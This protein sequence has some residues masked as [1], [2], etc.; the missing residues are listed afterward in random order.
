MAGPLLNTKF[1]IPR[2]RTSTVD[3]PRVSDL[4]DQGA[5]AKL[6]VLSAQAGFGKTTAIANWVHQGP[7]P[8]SVSWVSLESTDT[9]PDT[10]WTYVVTALAKQVP[11][12]TDSVLPLL[13][14]AKAP[15][16]AALTELLNRLAEA[17]HE[18]YLVLDDY[19][20]AET[21]DV[22]EGMTFLLGNLPPQAHLLLSTRSDPDLPLSRLRARGE[23]VEV[24]ASD[25]RFTTEEV[26][27]YL[28]GA[29]LHLRPSDLAVLAERTEGW[30]AALQL[31]AL[32]LRDRSDISD[33]IADFAGDDRFIVDY[34]VDEV[35]ARQPEPV[36]Q[37]LVRTCILE[38]LT[39]PLCDAVTGHAASDLMLH[40]LDRK[41][42][43]VIPLDGRRRWYR[44]HHL[45]AD[46]LRTH[47]DT[48]P[49]GPS[50]AELHSR[51]SHWYEDDGQPVDAVRHALAAGNHSRAATLMEVSLPDLLRRRQE[52]TVRSWIDTLSDDVVQARPVLA[53]GFVAALM[54]RNEFDTVPRRLD[55]LEQLLA[56]AGGPGVID[57]ARAPGVIVAK[58]PGVI[59]GKAP[60]IIVENAPGVIVENQSE[61]PR[62]AGRA[63]LYRAALSL[64]AGDTEGTHRHGR[65]ATEISA[66][67]DQVTRA[68]AWALSGLAHWGAGD[69]EAAHQCYTSCVD[70]LLQAG[71]VSDVLGCSIT[72]ADLRVTQGRLGDARATYERALDLAAQEPDVLRG[73]PDMHTGLSMVLLEHN[74]IDT[75]EAHLR[76]AQELGEAAGLPQH[77]YRLRV[78]MALARH[79]RGDADEAVALLDEAERVYVGDFSPDVRPVHAT[80]ARLLVAH[81]R[82]AQARAWADERKL[83]GS[84][85]LTYVH[86][87]EHVTLAMLLLAEH[88]LHRSAT[89]LDEAVDLLRRL[90]GNTEGGG[91]TGTLIEVLVLQALASQAHGD[92]SAAV[93]TLR[94]ALTLAAPERF[95]QVFTQHG[96]HLLT[97]LRA[98]PASD[99]SPYIRGL[100]AGCVPA[101]SGSGR[102]PDSASGQQAL[103]DPLSDRELVVLRLL[104]S[105]LPGPDLARHLV[106]SLNTLRTHTR[107]IY[108]KLG[109]NGRRGAVRRGRELGLLNHGPASGDRGPVSGDRSP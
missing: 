89:A 83:S 91:R 93:S 107:N 66:P 78:A 94:Q 97:V 44:Y 58:A 77:P 41:N 13:G 43:F 36:R 105:D 49:D 95:G 76:R 61:V 32:S 42:L 20:L 51:A 67:D 75:A 88:E 14:A 3:R 8:E 48:D 100:M 46:V 74:E 103:V 18:V 92:S 96:Q 68:G 22:A 87:Y 72:L 108:A 101:D 90:R 29:G 5:K 39:G 69:L 54:T 9:D 6:T 104:A 73:T 19:H 35:L 27:S 25:L 63:E 7:G 60:G 79:A 33:F 99:R 10:F 53:M 85:E 1:F 98:F 47:L 15:H 50:V 12:I 57:A 24:R 71:N 109:V 21:P 80:R 34:L 26:A 4:L 65:R 2:P 45:F 37:F 30:V 62:L 52:S 82:I 38:R 23:V 40:D 59:V 11:A 56:Q 64:V 86:E 102:L 106:V 81:G 55:D 16:T 17:S 84:E 28:H 31:A 70:G